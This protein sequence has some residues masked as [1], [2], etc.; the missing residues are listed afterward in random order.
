[1]P[2]GGPV[3]R[4]SQKVPDMPAAAGRKGDRAELDSLRER[5]RGRGF[6][7]DGFAAEVAGA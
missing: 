5:M 3:M 1:M 7:Q 6:S 4:A 2:A